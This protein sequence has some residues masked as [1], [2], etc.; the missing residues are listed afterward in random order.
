M[1]VKSLLLAGALVL[2]SVPM[3]FGMSYEVAFATPVQ[4][5]NATLAPGTYRVR[6]K[7]GEAIFRNIATGTTYDVSATVEHVASKN[8]S[9]KVVM[10]SRNGEP[11]IQ[12]IQVGGHAT[13]L[14]FS[15]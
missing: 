14:Q 9:E 6:A 13:D 2:A 10:S 3:A 15:E 8:H 11:R 12:S 1:S 5:G 7:G 4:A